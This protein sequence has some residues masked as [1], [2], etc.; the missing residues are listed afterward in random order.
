MITVLVQYGPLDWHHGPAKTGLP[1]HHL[2]RPPHEWGSSR[3]S[4]FGLVFRVHAEQCIPKHGYPLVLGRAGQ[5]SL[6]ATW[7]DLRFI[8]SV[9]LT[10]LLAF[11]ISYSRR[12]ASNNATYHLPWSVL[13]SLLF[14]GSSWND[15]RWKPIFL[16][17]SF[18]NVVQWSNRFKM[19]KHIHIGSPCYVV[20]EKGGD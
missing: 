2:C 14:P 9:R 17:S 12:A 19:Q 4:L 13:E 6:V 1:P 5:R 18:G 11:A 20:D 3:C 15:I 16:R 8:H 10:C 7:K